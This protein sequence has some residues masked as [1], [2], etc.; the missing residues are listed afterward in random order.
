MLLW[1]WMEGND[2]LALYS[3]RAGGAIRWRFSCGDSGNER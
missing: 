3:I 1:M 2:S